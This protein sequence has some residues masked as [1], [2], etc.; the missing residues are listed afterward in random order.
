MD[1]HSIF[2]SRCNSPVA[3]FFSPRGEQLEQCIL[4]RNSEQA[5][6]GCIA[7][8]HKYC[9]YI[10]CG[11]L[12]QMWLL[13]NPHRYV[14]D[15]SQYHSVVYGAWIRI[16]YILCPKTYYTFGG[17]FWSTA[18]LRQAAR[19]ACICETCLLLKHALNHNNVQ[20]LHSIDLCGCNYLTMSLFNC[21]FR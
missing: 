6:A 17:L 1:L 10:K 13:W 11:A 12:Y 2:V 7:I 18:G 15:I 3:Q 21:W 19:S 20:K 14:T 5:S 16:Y 8:F 9:Y 4:D